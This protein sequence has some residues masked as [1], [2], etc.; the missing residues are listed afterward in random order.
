MRILWSGARCLED[1]APCTAAYSSARISA[2]GWSWRQQEKLK[3]SP[4]PPP[5]LSSASVLGV[6]RVRTRTRIYDRVSACYRFRS[7]LSLR[8]GVL[9]RAAPVCRIHSLEAC[10]TS[11]PP[12]GHPR[13]PTCVL[14]RERERERDG[15]RREKKGWISRH[16]SARATHLTSTIC[17][18]LCST[19]FPPSLAATSDGL[20]TLWFPFAMYQRE[21]TTRG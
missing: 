8:N 17:V 12:L 11:L 7:T 5:P 18:H 13:R 4:F 2:S 19:R 14:K 1:Y 15:E 16:V 3:A 20:K 6:R 10:A 9:V 21:S